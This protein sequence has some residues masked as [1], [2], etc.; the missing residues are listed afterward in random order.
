LQAAAALLPI[1]SINACGSTFGKKCM[2][3]VSPPLPPMPPAAG[4]SRGTAHTL[5]WTGS[6]SASW[7]SGRPPA[8]ALGSACW[9]TGPEGEWRGQRGHPLLAHQRPGQCA[10][11]LQPPAAGAVLGG[12]RPCAAG[13]P[14]GAAGSCRGAGAAGDQNLGPL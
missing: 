3:L 12:G 10:R 1:M 2:Q 9:S 4:L 11:R 13:L 7:V 8:P 14:R 5:R 6:P